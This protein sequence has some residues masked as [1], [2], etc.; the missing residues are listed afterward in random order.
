[1]C[2]IKGEPLEYTKKHKLNIKI[3]NNTLSKWS[4]EMNR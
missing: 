2:Q 1:M 3:P 4:K